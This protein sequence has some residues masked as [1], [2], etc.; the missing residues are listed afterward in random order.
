MLLALLDAGHSAETIPLLNLTITLWLK[1]LRTMTQLVGGC[2]ITKQQSALGQLS[3]EI[4]SN[5]TTAIK[6]RLI[7]ESL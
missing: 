2:H 1:D 6:Q 5:S 7:N 3:K 4:P